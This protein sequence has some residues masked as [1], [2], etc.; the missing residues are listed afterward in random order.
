MRRGIKRI[1]F[2]CGFNAVMI[3]LI[4]DLVGDLPNA[5]IFPKAWQDDP[6]QPSDDLLDFFEPVEQNLSI[7]SRVFFPGQHLP[8]SCT[9]LN[10]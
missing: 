7:V 10:D 5:P 6:R 1:D 4:K 9:T 8:L 2:L 3:I